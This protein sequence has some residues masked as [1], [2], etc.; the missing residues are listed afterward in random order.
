MCQGPPPARLFYR[1]QNDG[2]LGRPSLLMRAFSVGT[3]VISDPHGEARRP[4]LVGP[5]ASRLR[6]ALLAR[7]ALFMHSCAM[8]RTRSGVR[9]GRVVG[10]Q[11]WRVARHGRTHTQRWTIAH[12][13]M[14]HSTKAPAGPH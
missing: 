2:L 13:G 9:A 10:V 1:Y 3:A 14:A 4:G 8:G 5:V 6:R 7:L 12:T 11:R